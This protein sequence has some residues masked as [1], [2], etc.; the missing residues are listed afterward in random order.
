M[1]TYVQLGEERGKDTGGVQVGLRVAKGGGDEEGR[2][3]TNVHLENI[4]TI[5]NIVYT[6]FL[7]WYKKDTHNTDGALKRTSQGTGPPEYSE[8]KERS[9]ETTLNLPHPENPDSLLCLP[10][11]R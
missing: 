3:S 1:Q 2:K 4:I 11:G 9:S 8:L 10:Q 7:N 5:S 6:H